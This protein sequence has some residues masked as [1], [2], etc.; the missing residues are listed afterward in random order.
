MKTEFLKSL[1]L[2]EDVI[3]QIQAESGKDVQAEKD[4]TK[5]ASDDLAAMAARIGEYENKIQDFEKQDAAPIQSIA[6]DFGKSAVFRNR[7]LPDKC[8]LFCQKHLIARQFEPSPA[9]RD[10]R[11]S[12]QRT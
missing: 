6:G 11:T 7:R 2:S 1:G 3:A 4:K 10:S 8:L 9:P 12:K 5:K